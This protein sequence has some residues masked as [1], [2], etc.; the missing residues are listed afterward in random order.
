MIIALSVDFNKIL[1]AQPVTYTRPGEPNI[2][3]VGYVAEDMDRL[4]L[5]ELLFRNEEGQVENFNYEKMI[6]YV[7]EVLKTQDAINKDQ[8]VKIKKLEEENKILLS[9]LKK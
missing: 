7:V 4:G 5:E 1:E 3:E 2:W 9:E 8:N 6:L